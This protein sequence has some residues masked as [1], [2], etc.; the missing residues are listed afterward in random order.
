MFRQ[1]LTNFVWL[2]ICVLIFIV[3]G[4]WIGFQKGSV[5]EIFKMVALFFS[6][7]IGLHFY[8]DLAY[9]LTDFARIVKSVA[10]IFSYI[11][12]VSIVMFSFC[13]FRDGF[14]IMFKMGDAS[15]RSKVGGLVLGLIRG[16]LFGGI[17][18]FGCLIVDNVAL[19]RS[20]R[21]SYSGSILLE[22]NSNIYSSMHRFIVRPLFPK[23]ERRQSIKEMVRNNKWIF[24]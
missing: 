18:F 21:V 5:V 23:E 19:T 9:L 6:I 12:M 1:F 16:V 22:I 11:V 15:K 7:F 24:D 13:I 3:R 20:V 17:V 10:P 2:D 8:S 4:C 14:F